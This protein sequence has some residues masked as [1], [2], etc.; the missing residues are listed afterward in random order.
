M[1]AFGW[2]FPER[3]CALSCTE[4]PEMHG[5]NHTGGSRVQR[6]MCLPGTPW[7]ACAQGGHLLTFSLPKLV[8][9]GSVPCTQRHPEQDSVGEMVPGLQ[10][11]W[12]GE[13]GAGGRLGEK[14]VGQA[15]G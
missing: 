8:C 6:G 7:S 14:K 4:S 1:A 3:A 5:V 10:A 11:L 15:A 13:E 9:V 12:C 2:N